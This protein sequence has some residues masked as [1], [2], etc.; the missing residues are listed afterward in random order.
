MAMTFHSVIAALSAGD[1]F[2]HPQACEPL[3]DGGAGA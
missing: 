1:A 3:S 2:Q